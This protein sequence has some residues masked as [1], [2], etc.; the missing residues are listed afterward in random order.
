MKSWGHLGLRS[1]ECHFALNVN[2]TQMGLPSLRLSAARCGAQ[3]LL[4]LGDLALA[5]QKPL[6]APSGYQD[7]G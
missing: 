3:T 1:L 4:S 6:Q 5:Q 2:R 7:V